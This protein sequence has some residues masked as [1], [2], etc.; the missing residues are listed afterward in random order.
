MLADAQAAA[1]AAARAAAL[2]AFGGARLNVTGGNN[3]QQNVS[4]RT[5]EHSAQQMDGKQTDTEADN[6][7]QQEDGNKQLD[8]EADDTAHQTAAAGSTQ[9]NV[10]FSIHD[11]AARQDEVN[12]T[13]NITLTF[14]KRRPDRMGSR[15][16]GVLEAWLIARYHGWNFC[17]PPDPMVEAVSFPICTNETLQG[18]EFEYKDENITE[19]GVYYIDEYWNLKRNILSTTIEKI[20]QNDS[21]IFD[22]GAVEEWKRMILEAPLRPEM[23]KELWLHPDSVRIVAHVRRG[24][25]EEGRRNDIYVGDYQ[26]IALVEM[27]K[28]YIRLKRGDDVK[29]EVHVFS[30]SYGTTDWDRYGTLVDKFHLAPEGNN[31]IGLNLRDW[32]H[33]VRA[34]ILI[35]GNT[36]SN[37]PAL[38]RPA[39]PLS[40]GL[41]LTLERLRKGIKVATRKD[42]YRWKWHSKEGLMVASFP[43]MTITASDGYE[44]AQSR[45]KANSNRANMI[46]GLCNECKL[47]SV[48][49]AYKCVDRIKRYTEADGN[50]SAFVAVQKWVSDNKACSA[51]DPASCRVRVEKSCRGRKV[52]FCG[53]ILQI[54]SVINAQYEQSCPR[55]HP[56]CEGELEYL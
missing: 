8:A 12:N 29:I 48:P 17:S 50:Y 19:P 25:I 40:D 33:F 5:V 36:F 14:P 56:I 39:K 11:D 22:N 53:P 20:E 42:W 35:T 41:P 3:K 49:G 18:P 6:D 13:H 24:D 28:Y 1:R 31:D 9:L 21:S 15:I 47:S 46:E 44:V 34:D 23:D 26:I 52:W 38:A 43:N 30:E 27:S 16:R 54:E 4:E 51:C 7:A 37:V 32:K 10:T 45:D 55:I 2:R